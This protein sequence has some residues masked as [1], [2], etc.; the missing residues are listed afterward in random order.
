LAALQ[1]EAGASKAGAEGV[2]AL[3]ADH[4]AEAATNKAEVDL[5]QSILRAQVR[6]EERGVGMAW[7]VWWVWWVWWLW[8]CFGVEAKRGGRGGGSGE[9]QLSDRW[10]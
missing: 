8:V 6:S 4:R 5:I 1:L 9:E 7:W 10:W 2:A 3:A